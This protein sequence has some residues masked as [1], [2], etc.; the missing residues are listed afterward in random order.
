MDESPGACCRARADWQLLGMQEQ[1]PSGLGV[2]NATWV[3]A[4]GC[5]IGHGFAVPPTWHEEGG[6]S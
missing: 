1:R 4:A 6:A 5:C 2:M 3:G